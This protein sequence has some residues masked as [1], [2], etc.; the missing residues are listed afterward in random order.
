VNASTEAAFAAGLVTMGY[1]IAAVFFLKFWRQTRDRLF[2]T[3][4]LAFVLMALNAGLPTLLDIPREEQSP[5]F[6]LRLAAFVLIII[7]IIGKNVRRG[8]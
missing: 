4:A 1:A 2:M 7:A 6:L 8:G 3:F 5:F